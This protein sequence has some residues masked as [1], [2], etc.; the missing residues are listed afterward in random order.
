MTIR[1]RMAVA[2]TFHGIE[3]VSTG[4]VVDVDDTAGARYCSLGYAEPVAEDKKTENAAMPDT[5]DKR[6]GRS[7]K[8]E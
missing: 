3:N 1:M 4:D 2:G 5:S 7:R 8:G 6:R